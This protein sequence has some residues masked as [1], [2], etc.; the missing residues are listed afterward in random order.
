[1]AS[2]PRPQDAWP[3]LDRQRVKRFRVPR[4]SNHGPRDRGQAV[5]R[6]RSV[7]MWW[8]HV[9]TPRPGSLRA[10][11]VAA[12]TLAGGLVVA[13]ALA[14]ALD[15]LERREYDLLLRLRAARSPVAPIVI[16]AIDEASFRALGAWPFPRAVHALAIDRLREAGAAVIAIDI[17]FPEPSVPDP[18]A[19]GEKDGADRLLGA[20]VARAGNV[21]LAA[22]VTRVS[23][24][25]FTRMDLNPPVRP[26]RAGAA[27]VA[28]VN[29]GVDA[30]GVARRV[31]LGVRLRAERLP[32]FI[33]EVH[34]LAARAGITTAP[35]P[36]DDTLLI[37]FH[38]GPATFRRLPYHR[39]VAGQFERRAVAGRVALVGVTDP[40]LGD[41]FATA[42]DGH[43]AMPGVEVQANA[44][45]TL[46]TGTRLRVLPRPA[47][48]ALLMLVSATAGWLVARAHERAVLVTG[49]SI[50]AFAV[51]DAALFSALGWW[52]RSGL[53]MLGLAAAGLAA[54][55]AESTGPPRTT[56]KG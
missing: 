11:P 33:V 25:G 18:L 27:A 50:A 3:A 37:D 39:I 4:R 51:A 2:M 45:A 34:R 49:A 38:G 56:S 35:I 12:A 23:D 43:R 13:L 17:L 15:G 5:A 1:M 10:R 24:S 26:I 16:A 47:A 7:I 36:D 19:L 54:I 53:V 46:M 40:A 14:G 41:T 8:R 44:L 29:L 6:A 42:I 32:H 20:A 9:S 28:P 31:S 21:V 48:L 52:V 22:A 55:G 30:D